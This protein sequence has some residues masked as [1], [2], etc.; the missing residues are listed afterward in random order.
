MVGLKVAHPHWGPRK[1]RELYHRQQR[2]AASESTFKRVLE[3]SGWTRKRKR[4]LASQ[5]GRLCSGRQAQEPN[6]IWTV[7]LGH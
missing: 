1:L 3:R 6:Q 5:S 2:R 7:G 4:R